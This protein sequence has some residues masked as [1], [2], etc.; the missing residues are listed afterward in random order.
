MNGRQYRGYVYVDVEAVR[1]DS[2][3]DYWVGLALSY[4]SKAKGLAFEKRRVEIL[5]A[6]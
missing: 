6:C 4:N 5:V 2:N 3:L 1:T